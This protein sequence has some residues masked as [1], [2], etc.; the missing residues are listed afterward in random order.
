MEQDDRMI[1][2]RQ[3]ASL[4]FGVQTLEYSK[5]RK[6]KQYEKKKKMEKRKR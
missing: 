3:I 4:R 6:R 5:M 2:R 1:N